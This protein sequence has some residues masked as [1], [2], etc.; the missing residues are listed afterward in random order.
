V[1]F[2]LNPVVQEVVRSDDLDQPCYKSR[3]KAEIETELSN[4]YIG[5]IL[6]AECRYIYWEHRAFEKNSPGGLLL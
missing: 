2:F 1:Y 5:S 3:Q 6:G 4:A